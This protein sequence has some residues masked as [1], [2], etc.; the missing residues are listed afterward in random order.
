MKNRTSVDSARL[1]LPLF[2]HLESL[3]D[4]LLGIAIGFHFEPCPDSGEN[5]LIAKPGPE[6]YPMKS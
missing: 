1:S 6:H 5:G 3:F 4:T 2:D